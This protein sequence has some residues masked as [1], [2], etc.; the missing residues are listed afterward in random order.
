MQDVGRLVIRGASLI[1]IRS[2]EILTC[3]VRLLLFRFGLQTVAS[4][5]LLD[6]VFQLLLLCL[7]SNI[8]SVSLLG[9]AELHVT[10]WR[11]V[12]Q[13]FVFHNY[14]SILFYNQ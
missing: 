7:L 2:V 9:L 6:E 5:G 14:K 4:I 10:G 8:V 1:F 11:Y 3:H 12:I 13:V